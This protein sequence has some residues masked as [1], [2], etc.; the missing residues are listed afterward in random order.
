MHEFASVQDT[1][2][3]KLESLGDEMGVG[4]TFHLVPFQCSATSVRI[5][6][7]LKKLPAAM[8]WF[9][10]VQETWSSSAGASPFGW[11][12]VTGVQL[13]PFQR[14]PVVPTA[15]HAV[16]E[17]QETP[18]RRLRSMAALGVVWAAQLLPS[19]AS[20]SVTLVVPVD[21]EPTASHAVAE[22]QE[23]P[24]SPLEV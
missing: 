18:S 23:T 21:E 22:R 19:H 12:I 3:R 20:A 17:V 7:L 11:A 5:A 14:A 2:V 10:S 8:Q 13:V 16:A 4:W 15:M 24:R 1:S 6:S 9:R